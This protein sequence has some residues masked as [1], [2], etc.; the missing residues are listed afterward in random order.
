M[1]SRERPEEKRLFAHGMGYDLVERPSLRDDD[2]LTV[3]KDMN[4]VVHPTF[5]TETAYA[6]VCDNYMIEAD[7]VSAC[8]HRTEKK[9]FEL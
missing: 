1:R 2:P 4:I 8:L 5:Q 9:V 6:W 3:E 7:G